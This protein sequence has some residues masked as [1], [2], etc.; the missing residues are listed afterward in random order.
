[1]TSEDAFE[2]SSVAGVPCAEPHDNEVYAVF[3]VS[4]ASYPEG[5][6]M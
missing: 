6:G 2:V 5:D 4:V 3:D 1:M